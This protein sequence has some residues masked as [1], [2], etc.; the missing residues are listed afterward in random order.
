MNKN[1]I[2]AYLCSKYVNIN[3][4]DKFIYNYNK[5]DAEHD[6]KL[7]ICFKN[8]TTEEIEIRKNKL[9]D[10][11]CDYF[12]DYEKKNSNLITSAA[13]IT[14]GGLIENLLRSVPNNLSLNI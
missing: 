13:H 7:I 10:I 9:K 2:V 14:G 1:L 11:K 12:I 6:H 4:L 8:L 5:F 3:S